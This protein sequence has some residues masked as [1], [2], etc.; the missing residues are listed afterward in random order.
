VLHGSGT[1]NFIYARLEPAIQPGHGAQRSHRV[2]RA[3]GP[4]AAADVSPAA[5]V[6]HL[7]EMHNT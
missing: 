2:H 1:D 7:W 4:Q 5:I 3:D 6:A